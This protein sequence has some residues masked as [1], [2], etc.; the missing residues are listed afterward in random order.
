M[1]NKQ[2]AVDS[3]IS[4]LPLR[5]Q[6]YISKEVQEAKNMEKQQ[7]IEFA[8]E[9][10]NYTSDVDAHPANISEIEEYYNKIYGK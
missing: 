6:N 2:T 9:F 8:K 7:M 10:W 3:L 5:M 1:E 4:K